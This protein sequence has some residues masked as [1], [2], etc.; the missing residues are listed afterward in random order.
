VYLLI[1]LT[2]FLVAATYFFRSTS[3]NP[4][5]R[6]FDPSRGSFRFD[7]KR[8]EDPFQGRHKSPPPKRDGDPVDRGNM[9]RCH[10]C[11]VF[12]AE[13]RV[14]N[15]VIDGHILQFCSHTCRRNFV[16]SAPK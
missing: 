11:S 8:K 5:Y 6:S 15:E 4:K 10:N 1:A 3:A 9:L 12:F 7:R 16:Q 13:A 14:V 2:A